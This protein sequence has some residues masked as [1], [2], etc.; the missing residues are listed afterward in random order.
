MATFENPSYFRV[1]D[2]GR[3]KIEGRAYLD[4]ATLRLLVLSYG[5]LL[6][7]A[8][9]KE[10]ARD[11]ADVIQEVHSE[12]RAVLGEKLYCSL[13][14]DGS[15]FA[16]FNKMAIYMQS[17]AAWVDFE[18]KDKNLILDTLAEILRTTVQQTIKTLQEAG[19]H[20]SP[21]AEKTVIRRITVR[22]KNPDGKTLRE[23]FQLTNDP[24]S[25]PIDLFSVDPRAF[26]GISDNAY[27][28]DAPIL[29]QMA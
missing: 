4:I 17:N 7:N 19:V 10:D 15:M 27:D 9:L 16:S 28:I 24:L 3:L 25:V 12:F 29:P 2:E 23:R 18:G 22:R 21:R 13:I 1:I 14:S 6:T 20:V 11:C 26:R 8:G 5:R